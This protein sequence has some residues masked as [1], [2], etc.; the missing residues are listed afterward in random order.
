M[1]PS[2]VCLM[3]IGILLISFSVFLCVRFRIKST[4]PV[5]E[6]NTPDRFITTRVGFI[7][8]YGIYLVKDTVTGAEYITSNSHTLTKISP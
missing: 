4:P 6:V 8:N 1:K 7:N 3:L 5:E 2:E